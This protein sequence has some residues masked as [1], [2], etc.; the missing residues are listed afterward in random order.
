MGATLRLEP[1]RLA[2]MVMA[3]GV[4]TIPPYEGYQPGYKALVEDEPADYRLLTEIMAGASQTPAFPRPD[5]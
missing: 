4:N 1:G 2:A 5:A 3:G